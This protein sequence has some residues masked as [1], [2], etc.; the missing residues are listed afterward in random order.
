VDGGDREAGV[1]CPRGLHEA[2]QLRGDLRVAVQRPQQRL[3]PQEGLGFGGTGGRILGDPLGLQPFLELAG[4]GL[5]D[6]LVEGGADA[7]GVLLAALRSELTEAGEGPH[8]THTGAVVLRNDLPGLRMV[9][10][11]VGPLPPARAVQI[12]QAQ[13]T[14]LLP[15]G[16]AVLG[17]ARCGGRLQ[18]LRARLSI[19]Q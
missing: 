3:E 12:V 15:M 18:G 1:E 10:L 16:P 5:R 13:R 17:G 4:E 6:R 7:R 19:R 9:V 11:A 8:L 2:Q 14:C